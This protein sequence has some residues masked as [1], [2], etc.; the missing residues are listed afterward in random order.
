M[1]SRR[2]GIVALLAFLASV[3]VACESGVV[4][5]TDDVEITIDV[6]QVSAGFAQVHF[7]TNKKAFYLMSIQPV[8]EGIDPVKIAKTFMLLALDSAY[9]DYLDWRNKQ[10]QQLVPFVADFS[11]HSLQ[12]GTVDHCFTFLNPNTDY[13]VFAFAVDVNTNKPV[14]KLFCKQIRTERETDI[15]INFEYRVRGRWTYVYPKDKDGAI[16]SNIPWAGE[17]V[18]SVKVRELGYESP[19]SYFY[20]RLNDIMQSD[21]SRALFG[22][23]AQENT[24]V[25]AYYASPFEVGKTYYMGMVALDA[26][27]VQPLWHQVYDIYRF[28]WQGDSTELYF[29]PEHSVNQN[30]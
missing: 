17:L 15:P 20:A 9:V 23:Y 26:P 22:I 4:A 16:Q 6:Q 7:E 3:F 14:G 2:L 27:L 10:L 25:D 8:R 24:G 12:Y 28:T 21:H 18:D 30:W 11:S 5:H 29:T 19:A 1:I 13:W